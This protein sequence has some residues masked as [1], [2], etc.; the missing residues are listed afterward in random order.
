MTLD[1][2]AQLLVKQF[3]C[4][5]LDSVAN[6]KRNSNMTVKRESDTNSFTSHKNCPLSVPSGS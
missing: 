6:H 2:L 1:V 3:K 5:T 4:L